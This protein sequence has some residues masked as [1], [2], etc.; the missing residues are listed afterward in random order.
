MVTVIVSTSCYLYFVSSALTLITFYVISLHRWWLSSCI[1]PRFAAA[2]PWK[3]A[4]LAALLAMLAAVLAGALAGALAAVLAGALAAALAA[5]LASYI[6]SFSPRPSSSTN[7][8]GPW[9][10]RRWRGCSDQLLE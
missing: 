4:A 9:L 8:R 3:L 2:F 7:S 5:G 6:T 1:L 10:R